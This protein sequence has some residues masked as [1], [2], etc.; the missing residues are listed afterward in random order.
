MSRLAESL[1]ICH[2]YYIVSR[3]ERKIEECISV[4]FMKFLIFEDSF[5]VVHKMCLEDALKESK[6]ILISQ[7]SSS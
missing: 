4:Y 5:N 2:F 1:E 7:F 3:N 6:I